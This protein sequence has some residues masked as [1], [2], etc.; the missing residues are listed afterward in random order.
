MSE[1]IIS[2]QPILDKKL[3]SYGYHIFLKRADNQEVTPDDLAQTF[4][5]I[6]L[7]RLIGNNIGFFEI[8]R[9]IADSQILNIFPSDKVSFTLGKD[10]LRADVMHYI[11]KL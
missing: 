2:R 8:S 10:W 5:E 1:I 7:E 11:E 6:D 3:R 9:E 4:T